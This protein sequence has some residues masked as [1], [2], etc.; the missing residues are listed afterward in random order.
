LVFIILLSGILERQSLE[1]EIRFVVFQAA[2]L[3]KQ[4]RRAKASAVSWSA[5][6]AC[7]WGR[8]ASSIASR[9]IS[10]YRLEMGRSRQKGVN[11][12]TLI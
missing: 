8:L 3:G 1:F 2:P 12:A 11:K 5:D 9:V 6:D 4:G 10:I 7:L